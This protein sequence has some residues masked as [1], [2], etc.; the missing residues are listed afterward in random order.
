MAEQ[1]QA[2]PS[3]AQLGPCAIKPAVLQAGGH[4]DRV[5]IHLADPTKI[6]KKTLKTESNF[7]QSLVH[8]LEATWSGWRPKFFGTLNSSSECPDHQNETFIILENLT[9]RRSTPIAAGTQPGQ[10]TVEGREEHENERGGNYELFKHPNVIDI[11]LGQRL[12]DDVASPEKTERMIKA[13]LETTSAKFGIRLTG[14][15]LWDHIKGDYVQ[16]PKSFGKSIDPNGSDLDLRFNSLFPIR[17]DSNPNASVTERVTTPGIRN[18]KLT[19]S[20]GSIPPRLMKQIIDR[21]IIPK[22]TRII[23]HLSSFHWRIY[24]SSLLIVFETD[25]STLRDALSSHSDSV[26]ESLSTVK[27]IDFAHVHLADSPDLGLL[28]GLQSTLDLFEQLSSQLESA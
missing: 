16:I 17:P 22:I 14:A 1:C 4:Q 28:K 6:I 18:E 11:K 21:S 24:G 9:L 7:Y 12:Y 13:G 15:Q 5:S 10:T 26:I 27:L 19:Y 3:D 8:R 25:L 23:S 20:A 2:E